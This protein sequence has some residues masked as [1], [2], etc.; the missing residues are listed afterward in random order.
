MTQPPFPKTD[1]G[2]RAL[3]RFK[4]GEAVKVHAWTDDMP[5]FWQEPDGNYALILTPSGWKKRAT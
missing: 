1:A 3:P 4:R 2:L 5:I